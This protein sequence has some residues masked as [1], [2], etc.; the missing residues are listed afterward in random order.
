MRFIININCTQFFIIE[1]HRPRWNVLCFGQGGA[2][3]VECGIEAVGVEWGTAKFAG[4]R[5]EA[6]NTNYNARGGGH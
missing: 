5:P 3:V 4:P 6:E 1:R 2:Y